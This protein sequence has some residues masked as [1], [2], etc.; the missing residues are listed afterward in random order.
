MIEINSASRLK[1][2]EVEAAPSNTQGGIQAEVADQLRK[3]RYQVKMSGSSI[4]VLNGTI[5]N[6]TSLLKNSG[7]TFD[8][9]KSRLTHGQLDYYINLSMVGGTT[10]LSVRD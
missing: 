7:W 2:T 6:V 9:A 8:K 3:A 1:A 5:S 4:Q 10:T